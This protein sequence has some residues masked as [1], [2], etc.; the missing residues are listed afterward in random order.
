MNKLLVLLSAGEVKED[1]PADL[2][3]SNFDNFVKIFRRLFTP[4]YE[5]ALKNYGLSTEREKFADLYDQS[6]FV[7]CFRIIDGL[8]FT[9][10]RSRDCIFRFK[11]RVP[12]W[13][14]WFS[15]CIS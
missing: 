6:L 8:R 13:F 1:F 3:I 7:E 4:H 10:S 12:F 15:S 5:G 14:V 11:H 2:K 9:D